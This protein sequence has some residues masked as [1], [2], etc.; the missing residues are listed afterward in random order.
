M[1]IVVLLGLMCV[2]VFIVNLYCIVIILL[3]KTLHRPSHIAICSLLIAHF[4]QSIFVIPSYAVKKA[5]TGNKTVVCD[6]FRFSYFFT[7]Y[8]SC[9]SLLV[10]TLDRFIGVRLPLKYHIIV[11]TRR[12]LY[13]TISIW[14][15]SLLL[16]LIPF[17]PNHA[18]SV[19]NYNPQKIWTVFMLLGNTLL[20][21]LIIAGCYVV[22]FKKASQVFT[23]RKL[24]L[25]N[26]D[27]R[28]LAISHFNKSKITLLIVFFYVLCWGPSC[29]YYLLQSLCKACFNS[30]YHDSNTE[31]IIHF[32]MKL[33]TF[34]DGVIAP[35]IYC[36]TNATFNRARRR[37]YKKLRQLMQG[38]S[39]TECKQQP[40][41]CLHE[42]LQEA[43]PRAADG[44]ASVRINRLH[45]VGNKNASKKVTLST[46]ST[47]VRT[48]DVMYKE[49]SRDT[50]ELMVKDGNGLVLL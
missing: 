28:R 1:E 35:L 42:H 23:Q 2:T 31:D 29:C 37:M 25:A 24:A 45:P 18:Q 20:P 8:A 43:S 50:A 7:N 38:G 15:Y 47:K 49:K 32:T 19:C 21:F 39:V 16:S 41:H 44:V 4:L 11:S 6:T 27:T 13:L 26:T 9:L 30:S 12:M 3:N 17:I 14:M 22:I 10:I 48:I 34:V 36:C 5:G 40:G 33:L 46:S